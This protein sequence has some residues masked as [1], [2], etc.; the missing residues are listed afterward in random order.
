[1]NIIAIGFGKSPS[2]F[3]SQP[4]AKELQDDAAKSQFDIKSRL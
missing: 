4:V 3:A 2:F 1:M